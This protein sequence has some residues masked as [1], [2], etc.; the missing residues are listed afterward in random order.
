MEVGCYTLDMYCDKENPE[1]KYGEFPHQF[2]GE[3][4]G[5]TCRKYARQA[6]WTFHKDGTHS[7]PKCKGEK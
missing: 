7:C 2:S 5:A 3:E 4:Y 6:G 1:H